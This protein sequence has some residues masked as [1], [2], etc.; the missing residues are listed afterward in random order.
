MPINRR[1][2]LI[3]VA[4]GAAF[5]VAG[6]ATADQQSPINTLSGDGS[7]ILG[8]DPVAYFVEGMPRKGDPAIA[9]EHGGARWLFASEANKRRFEA[10]P[11]RYVPAYGGYCAYGTARGYLVEI[12]PN[13]WAIV[14]DKLYL[15]YD[16]SVQATWMKD[17]P[18][19]IRRAD[20]Q[21][22][23]LSKAK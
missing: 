1:H 17:V 11:A 6:V 14:K 15:N 3:A 19:Y 16:R 9:V 18:G 2:I 20:A 4:C 5:A 7:A 13:A 23:R 8:Y 12:D 21:W 10:D 22:P